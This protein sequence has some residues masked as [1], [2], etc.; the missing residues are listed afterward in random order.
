MEPSSPG[1]AYPSRRRSLWTEALILGAFC[2]LVGGIVGRQTLTPTPARWVFAGASAFTAWRPLA[3]S[4]SASGPSRWALRPPAAAVG[5]PFKP[6]YV[7]SELGVHHHT[8]TGAMELT[9]RALVSIPDPRMIH[10]C[11]SSRCTR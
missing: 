3:G 9:V 6:Y 4:D 11:S 10:S 5:S 7:P 1:E 8:V 2:L